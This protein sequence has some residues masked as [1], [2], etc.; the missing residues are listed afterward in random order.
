MLTLVGGSNGSYTIGQHQ[1]LLGFQTS[2]MW[3]SQKLIIEIWE[4]I[5][6]YNIVRSINNNC[7]IRAFTS[8][9][10]IME[11]ERKL[12]GKHHIGAVTFFFYKCIG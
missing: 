5:L 9:K 6:I 10:R 12:F 7:W 4:S 8:I 2:Q 3:S 11:K 1:S